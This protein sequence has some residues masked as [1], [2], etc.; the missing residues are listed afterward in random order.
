MIFWVFILISVLIYI[1]NPFGSHLSFP[2]KGKFFDY[3]E[4]KKQEKENRRYNQ[5]I[6]Q[7]YATDRRIYE[8][9]RRTEQYTFK[10]FYH[11]LVDWEEIII[12]LCLNTI[13]S[14]F[15]T[16]IISAIVFC[17]CP[18][19]QYDYT[20]EIKSLKDNM[21]TSGEFYRGASKNTYGFSG[22]INGQINYYF[23]REMEHGDKVGHIPADETYIYYDNDA[24]PSITVFTEYCEIAPWKNKWFFDMED[25]D[26]EVLY[27]VLT[28]PENT[29]LM[30]DLFQIDME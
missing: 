23:L 30:N 12:Y 7:I 5:E 3:I 2:P 15:L 13:I 18:K 10:Q 29:I 24:V 9:N 19:I 17:N 22:S 4:M 20:F 6:A 1:F 25:D 28:V 8:Y 16:V 21:V 27:Y 14:W 26:K 11:K